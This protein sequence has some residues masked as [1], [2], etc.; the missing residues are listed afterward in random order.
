M[1]SAA[2]TGVGFDVT[3]VISPHIKTHRRSPALALAYGVQQARPSLIS[4]IAHLKTLPVTDSGTG[5]AHLYTLPVADSGTGNTPARATLR[6]R[7]AHP[8]TLLVA[9]PGTGPLLMSTLALAPPIS[10]RCWSPTLVLAH[11]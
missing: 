7:V 9:D 1:C 3:R 8:D 2:G 6:H 5:V 4:Y 11:C 10:I